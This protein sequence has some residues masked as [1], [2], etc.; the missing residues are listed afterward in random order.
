MS[1]PSPISPTPAGIADSAEQPCGETKKLLE[2]AVQIMRS[3]PE[4]KSHCNMYF[5]KLLETFL[6]TSL[7]EL[8]FTAEAYNCEHGSDMAKLNSLK[9]LLG[10][11]FE[12]SSSNFEETFRNLKVK[13]CYRRV[14]PLKE[15]GNFDVEAASSCASNQVITRS[16][17]SSSSAS[18]KRK[19]TSE[20][21]VLEPGLLFRAIM[22]AAKR[23][24]KGG[25]GW[26]AIEK[27]HN[28]TVAGAELKRRR[29]SL[30]YLELLQ[31]KSDSRRRKKKAMRRSSSEPAPFIS[32]KDEDDE[33]VD[34][35]ASFEDLGRYYQLATHSVH[36]G[37]VGSMDIEYSKDMIATGGDDCTAVLFDYS[38]RKV[39][40]TLTGHS[41]KV[42]AVK[43]AV[44]G[45]VFLTGSADKTVRIWERTED[46]SYVYR[47]TFKNHTDEV[48]A[49][50]VNAEYI[51]TASLDATWWLYDLYGDSGSKVNT[52]VRDGSE[53]AGYTA[54]AFHPEGK[55][56]G[57]GT[58][59]GI[60]K[61]WDVRK[62]AP[63]AELGGGHVEAVTA[64][65]FSE[66]HAL[67]A[68]A[69]EDG[70][71]LW[72]CRTWEQLCIPEFYDADTPAN[73]VTFGHG[74]P[75][76]GVATSSGIRVSNPTEDWNSIETRTDTGRASCLGF[77]QYAKYLAVG[78]VNGKLILFGEEARPECPETTGVRG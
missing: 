14:F 18:T 19:T 21:T 11:T 64:M 66:T 45:E 13:Y 8:A 63:V 17:S 20:E 7:A 40:A 56:L 67:L 33:V 28:Q 31:G 72:D 42:T 75:Y 35:L 48:R 38:S 44:D 34:T 24:P 77:G 1:S 65:S 59:G 37:R 55:V 60:V 52:T 10:A 9:D 22:L 43:F 62:Q 16:S 23:N 61:I 41:K 58:C 74:C 6:N 78:S 57:L 54:A 68:T 73:S 53:R 39:R 30:K 49:I 12:Y 36:Q 15:P 5:F 50:A 2:L 3:D 70:V 51:V 4:V 47:H 69:A 29:P 46:E 25:F 32:S 71:K 76:L 26:P 27:Q